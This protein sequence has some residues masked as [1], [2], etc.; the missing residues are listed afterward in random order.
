MARLLLEFHQVLSSENGSA[1]PVWI[2][3]YSEMKKGKIFEAYPDE[4]KTL[5]A[6]TGLEDSVFLYRHFSMNQFTIDLKQQ[7]AEGETII[8]TLAK[9]GTAYRKR[10]FF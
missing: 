3:G 6:G 2:I 10:F 8:Q 1:I 7:T 4:F 5:Y 9:I